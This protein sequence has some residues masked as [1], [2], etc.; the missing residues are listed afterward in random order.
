MID[1]DILP[2]LARELRPQWDT[3]EPFPHVVIDDFLPPNT[4]DQVLDAFD[5]AV[6]GWVFHNHYNERKYFNNKK[7]LMAPGMKELLSDF[8]SPRWLQFLEEVTGI[9]NLL[10]DPTLEGGAGLLRNLPGCYL[11]IHRESA[12]HGRNA[13]WDR[14]LNLLLYLNK[15][16]KEEWQ[17][18][19][20]L[21]DYRTHTCVKSI[22]PNFNRMLIFRT[23]EIAFHGHPHKLMCPEGVMRRSIALYYFT[24]ERKHFFL[25]PVHYQAEASDGPIR[26]TRIA[27]GNL[28]L[29]LYFP[30]RKYTP[31]NDEVVE[32]VMR[33]LRITKD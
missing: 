30:L 18:N 12:T 8:E 26:R 16:W 29:R 7:E 31:I 9:P 20:E 5:E 10:A 27:L 3:A 2:S 32:K 13:D 15:G 33:F 19:L 25:K 1:V 22:K 23:N 4:A 28:A 6:K 11:N 24:K 14:K 17:G 21:H